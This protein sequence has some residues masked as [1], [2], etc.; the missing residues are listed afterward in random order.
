MILSLL[1][2]AAAQIAT[3]PMT[4]QAAYRECAT[5][6]QTDPAK[7]VE[8][9][10]RWLGLD[11]GIYAYQCRALAYVSLE[12][13]ASAGADF[14]AAAAAAQTAGDPR[15]ADLWAKAG[16]AW[17]AGDD[18]AKARKA[19]DAAL[20]ADL[21]NPAL[22]GQIHLDRARASV[23]LGDLAGARTDIDKG[24]QLAPAEALGWYLSSALAQ[25]QDDLPRAQADIAK[26][27]A[28]APQD[29]D[30]LLQAGNIAGLSGEVEAAKALL[31]RAAK[32]APDSPAGRAAQAALTANAAISQAPQ[33]AA[34]PPK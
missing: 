7:A 4:E 27:V 21:A 26:A 10:G 30:I 34:P 9:A 18:A 13:W 12:R 20:A 23:A 19:F 31:A 25:R 16:N 24:L 14:E 29:A 17:L 1:A 28:L 32:A 22:R 5:M 6:A 8:L 11:G 2:L 33:P 15:R 3:A